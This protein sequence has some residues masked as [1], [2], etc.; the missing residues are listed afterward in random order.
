MFALLV[1]VRF[2]C[3]QIAL[4][5]SI[6]Q[7]MA[8]V[9]SGMLCVGAIWGG[10]ALDAIIS[11]SLKSH[12]TARGNACFMAKKP[13]VNVPMDLLVTNVNIVRQRLCFADFS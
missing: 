9:F 7:G 13:P 8:T 10:W 4:V 2:S 11:A 6:V 5:K 1:F 3:S 12:A